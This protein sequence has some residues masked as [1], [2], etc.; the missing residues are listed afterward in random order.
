MNKILLIKNPITMATRSKQIVAGLLAVVCGANV[1]AQ[2]LPK[3]AIVDDYL[4]TE[5]LLETSFNAMLEANKK[6][7][8]NA[9]ICA[10]PVYERQFAFPIELSDLKDNNTLLITSS[11]P[12]ELKSIEQ[13]DFKS[14]DEISVAPLFSGS[15]RRSILAGM[16]IQDMASMTI[17]IELNNLN[18]GDYTLQDLELDTLEGVEMKNFTSTLLAVELNSKP[19][20]LKF[21]ADKMH[22]GLCDLQD[23]DGNGACE[24]QD[25]DGVQNIDD[26]CQAIF[27]PNQADCDGDGAGDV[28][29]ID[30]DLEDTQLLNSSIVTQTYNNGSE[31]GI[32]TAGQVLHDTF[33]K[34]TTRNKVY[35]TTF[36]DGSTT[37]YTTHH[38]ISSL[39]CYSPQYGAQCNDSYV[40]ILWPSC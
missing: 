15:S 18:L 30:D 7:C 26:N 34:V 40:P 13:I 36:C 12:G 8:Q 2:S 31:C 28:C 37:T 20:I 3:D 1:F 32:S 21:P 5:S 19:P 11:Y 39:V 10:V 38:F 17:N 27:N 9:G 23:L 14:H 16:D 35:Q 6:H 22:P 24:D 29:D 4:A 25:N 33:E